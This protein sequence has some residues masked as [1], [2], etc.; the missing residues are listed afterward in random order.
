MT[1]SIC[2]TNKFL[3]F[4]HSHLQQLPL[5]IRPR[6]CPVANLPATAAYPLDEPA[7]EDV[8]AE[9]TLVRRRAWQRIRISRQDFIANGRKTFAKHAAD[10]PMLPRL[11]DNICY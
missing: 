8:P 4:P 9:V 11:P 5:E 10:V 2:E 6:S 1:T 3:A 7:R